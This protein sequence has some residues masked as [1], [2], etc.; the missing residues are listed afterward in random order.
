MVVDVAAD[1]KT[2]SSGDG[3]TGATFGTGANTAADP[4]GC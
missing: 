3:K 1:G 2:I 4:P